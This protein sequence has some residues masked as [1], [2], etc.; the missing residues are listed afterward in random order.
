M[1]LI[2]IIFQNLNYFLVVFVLKY[3]TKVK[4]TNNTIFFKKKIMMFFFYTNK[5]VVCDNTST[6]GRRVDIKTCRSAFATVVSAYHRSTRLVRA[7][8][9][10]GARASL[11]CGI[12]LVIC[13]LFAINFTIYTT[14]QSLFNSKLSFCFRLKNAAKSLIDEEVWRV[15]AAETG[16]DV[17]DVLL[18][19]YY[20][21]MACCG[22]REF[23]QA[24][25]LFAKVNLFFF[26]VKLI[27]LTFLL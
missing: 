15:D 10:A 27:F 11:R 20:A 12:Q 25:R 18:Y 8:V 6:I 21:G 7:A 14:M 3:Y 2:F 13:C 5:T 9:S 26:S 16:I 4:T 22:T 17:E 23:V 19:L 24:R 1:K